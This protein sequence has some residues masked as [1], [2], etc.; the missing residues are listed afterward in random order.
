M[1]SW[2]QSGLLRGRSGLE[3]FLREH[4][5]SILDDLAQGLYL[6]TT[7]VS[8]EYFD[9]LFAFDEVIIRMRAGEVTQS[10]VTMLFDYLCERDGELR[11]M[12]RG[13]QQIACLR[14]QAEGM[15]ATPVPTALR[16]G[17]EPFRV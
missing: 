8:C 13:E 9:E 11:L 1:R 14:K 2:R 6:V 16:R 7:R 4:A 17:L 12:A 3:L 10:R 15:V 5:P